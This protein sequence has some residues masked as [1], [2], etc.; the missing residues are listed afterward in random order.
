MYVIKV[1][2]EKCLNLITLHEALATN[3][4][5]PLLNQVVAKCSLLKNFDKTKA[6]FQL[7]WHQ[8]SSNN[9]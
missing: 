7:L 6:D 3:L 1:I 4:G 2:Q 8:Q 9:Y 5:V